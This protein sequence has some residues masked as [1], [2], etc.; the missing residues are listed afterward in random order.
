MLI[1]NPKVGGSIPPPATNFSLFPMTHKTAAD[2]RFAAVFTSLI[3]LIVA[4]AIERNIGAMEEVREKKTSYVSH[5]G[6]RSRDVKTE[7]GFV[8]SMT[9][10]EDSGTLS[11]CIQV[12]IS[13]FVVR[14]RNRANCIMTT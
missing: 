9:R 5:V 3:L 7:R 14:N 4:T 11:V 6:K 13:E 8:S 1:H 10:D 2:C 12:A